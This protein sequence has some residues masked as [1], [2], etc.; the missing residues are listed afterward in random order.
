[1]HPRKQGRQALNAVGFLNRPG[2]RV[3]FSLPS[4]ERLSSHHVWPAPA[5]CICSP[6]FC[7]E[8]L[9]AC[10]EGLA[11]HEDPYDALVHAHERAHSLGS[12]TICVAA[13]QVGRAT[14][15]GGSGGQE[16]QVQDWSE[17][18]A[19]CSASAACWS[20]QGLKH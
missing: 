6:P 5:P 14:W 9:V 11:H 4:L 12:C 1:M 19:A 8:L 7:R 10:E 20:C 15:Q 17:G 16:I 3:T 18:W 2:K 13:L